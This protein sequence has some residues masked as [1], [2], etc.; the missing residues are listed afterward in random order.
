[1]LQEV[2]LYLRLQQQ[3]DDLATEARAA[4]CHCGGRLHSAR[5][6]R[7]PRGGP[8]GI[9]D[10]YGRR[11][12]FC[13]AE[14]GCR[15]RVTPPSVRFLGRKVYLGAVVVVLA[16]LRQTASAVRFASVRRY[17]GVSWRTLRR[18]A[19]WWRD[20][21]ASGRFWKA[22]QGL[23]APPAPAAA[24]LPAA[25]IAVFG[26]DEEGAADLDAALRRADHDSER[27][28]RW[29]FVMGANDPQKM[30]LAS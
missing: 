14:E 19:A 7:K 15:R 16:A 2:R 3:D 23:L 9:G 30:S 22:A 1:L 10:E 4:G 27:E 13:C 20:D 17:I 12:S 6:R 18:W 29:R 25:L 11:W 8:A 28:R 5:Y 24:M 21:F 26:G